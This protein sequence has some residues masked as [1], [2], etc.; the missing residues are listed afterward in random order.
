MNRKRAK[1]TLRALGMLLSALA[2]H[3]LGVAD[4]ATG[5]NMSHLRAALLFLAVVAAIPA[6]AQIPANA[7]GPNSWTT[8]APMPT[9]LQAPATGVIGGIVYVVGGAGGAA[10]SAEVNINQ[11]YNPETNTWA[12][13]APMPTAR[14]GPVGAVVNNILYVIGGYLNGNSLNVVEAFDSSS[15]T[16]STKAPMPTPRD[17]MP[18][19]VNGGVIYVIGGVNSH[20]RLT[21]VESYN[22]ATDTWA[23][24]APLPVGVSGVAAGLIGSTVVAAGGQA[25]SGNDVTDTEG[26]N[27]STNS[28]EA[29]APDP[30]AHQ[31]GCF[32][33]IL[34]QLYFA[35]GKYNGG[36]V[37]VAE[38]FNL[39][40][41]QWN[42]LAPMPLATTN[43]GY[44]E[45]GNLLYCFGGTNIGNVGVGTV[46]NSVQ[47]YHPSAPP[48][49]AIGAGGVVSASAFGE[50]TSVSP[51]SWIEIYGSNLAIDSRSWAASDFTGV[52]APTS[53][54]GTSVTIGGQAAFIDFISPGQV[55]ALVPSNVATGTQPMTVTVG[56]VTSAASSIN[57][58]PVEPGLDAPPSFKIGGVQYAVALFADGAYVL[59][60]GAIAGLNSR[61]AQPGDE[62]VLY[63]VG[64]GPVTPNISAG[65]L[66]Q[67]AN[68]LPSSFEMSIGGVPVTNVPYSGLA[69]SY[70]GLYQFNIV[71]PANTG[72]G[73][74]PV[75][76]T[77][78]GVAG[79]QA[80]YL[81]VG[82]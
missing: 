41:N 3:Q 77:V 38:S 61:P 70:T 36:A 34:G 50:F 40:E 30:T 67:Q 45:V 21:T 43:P 82:N 65:Q 7:Q 19:V 80:L 5:I 39:Q 18:A 16:W 1:Q 28:W 56:G 79:T 46:Y 57:V 42:T 14:Q 71:V 22:P 64:F 73:A 54:D 20:G 8:G 35:G 11:V 58:N 27:P 24:D 52:D 68:A 44:A 55:N 4:D 66:V 49:P 29:L 9:A 33:T 2:L 13:G 12:T 59:P 60:E 48:T 75:T 72:S 78:D 6:T 17:S 81:A 32:S 26:Y 25:G 69:P 76:F 10:N 37:N 47:I 63:G 53:L 15:N 51:G 31:A 23:E 62:I 74:L